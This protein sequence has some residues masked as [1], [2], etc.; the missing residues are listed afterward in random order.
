MQLSYYSLFTYIYIIEIQSSTPLTLGNEESSQSGFVNNNTS[1][2]GRNIGGNYMFV[3]SGSDRMETVLMQQ[4][5]FSR[6][7]FHCL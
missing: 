3:L 2:K 4:A 7:W 1:A 6:S 5:L